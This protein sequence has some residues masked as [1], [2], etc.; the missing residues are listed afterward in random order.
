[1][2]IVNYIVDIELGMWV[3]KYSVK[4]NMVVDGNGFL[5]Y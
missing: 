4:D 1:M 5:K 3:K 2:I